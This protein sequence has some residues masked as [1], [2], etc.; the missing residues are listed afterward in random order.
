MAIQAGKLMINRINDLIDKNSTFSIETTLLTRSYKNLIMKAKAKGYLV[1][2]LFF[3]LPSPQMAVNRVASRVAAGGHNIPMD[4]IHRRY[5]A[6]LRNLF[7]V[8]APIV[9][10]WSL[11]DNSRN[12]SPIV[13]FNEIV[14]FQKLSKIKESCLKRNE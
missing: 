7:E 1:V 13:E 5:W 4:V 14:D 10:A 3:W 6:G 2:L 8:F 12:L 9:D 11:Y